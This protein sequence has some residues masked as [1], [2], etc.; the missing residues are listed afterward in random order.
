[1]APKLQAVNHIIFKEL[2]GVSFK[3]NR[4]ITWNVREIKFKSR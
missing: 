3:P 4:G 2:M 1:L